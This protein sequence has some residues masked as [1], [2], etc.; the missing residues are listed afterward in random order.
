MNE[1][2][3]SWLL[4]GW[5]AL[6]GVVFVALFLSARAPGGP[7][8]PAACYPGPGGSI[9]DA[10]ERWL[11]AI[12]LLLADAV[13]VFVPLVAIAAAYVVIARPDWFPDWVEK[14]YES[15]GERQ[16]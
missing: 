10:K 5:L 8:V 14:L 6:A 7:T 2:T 12:A 13:A 15:D 1:A 9:M 3:F 11:L 4:R 16:C